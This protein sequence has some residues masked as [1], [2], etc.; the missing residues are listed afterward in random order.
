VNRIDADVASN[1]MGRR[2]FFGRQ[3]GRHTPEAVV[4]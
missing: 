1:L 2:A 4:G 3:A